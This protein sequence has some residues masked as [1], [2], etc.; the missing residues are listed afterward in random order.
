[1][2]KITKDFQQ[3]HENQKSY[4]PIPSCK[5]RLKPGDLCHLCLQATALARRRFWQ[6]PTPDLTSTSAEIC[7]VNEANR[8]RTGGLT[9]TD[10]FRNLRIR[11]F[12]KFRMIRFEDEKSGL[13]PRCL[14]ILEAW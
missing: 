8:W 14:R 1:M 4:A 3:L 5:V 6:Q 13:C 10:G 11:H 9:Q 2:A 12:V 7:G